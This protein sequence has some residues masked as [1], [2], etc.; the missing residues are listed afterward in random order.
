[1]HYI[2]QHASV[3]SAFH[4]HTPT[5]SSD[6]ESGEE[7]GDLEDEDSEDAEK[8][9]NISDDGL[10]GFGYCEKCKKHHNW[11]LDEHMDCV[12]PAH[13]LRFG[14]NVLD[15]TYRNALLEH[16][17]E[18]TTEE[19]VGSFLGHNPHFPSQGDWL[20]GKK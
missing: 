8:S 7:S 10:G 20:A 15:P 3:P 4:A 11:R 9:P 18:Y 14:D 5:V 13:V 6:E 2:Q 12:P 16:C 19:I 17:A 1:M